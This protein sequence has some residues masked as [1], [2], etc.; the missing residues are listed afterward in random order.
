[1]AAAAEEQAADQ[2]D[3]EGVKEEGAEGRM[4]F[5]P[6]SSFQGAR[7]GFVFKMGPRGLGYYRDAKQEMLKAEKK[8]QKEEEKQEKKDD[9]KKEQKVEQ[10][11]E[12]TVKEEEKDE[13]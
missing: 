10:K 1:M 13:K 2:Q 8:E 4:F 3:G 6:A 9:E 12:P 7:P 5:E 11:Q